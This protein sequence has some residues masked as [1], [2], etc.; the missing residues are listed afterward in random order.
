V[1]GT[2]P[3]GFVQ[4]TAAGRTEVGCSGPHGALLIDAMAVA[5]IVASDPPRP[6]LGGQ[7]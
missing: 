3:P 5:G 4:V 1:L 7:A 6:A 2:L